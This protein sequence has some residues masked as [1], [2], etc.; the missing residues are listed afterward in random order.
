MTN[1]KKPSL[2]TSDEIL[3]NQ[4]LMLLICG[5]TLYFKKEKE[6]LIERIVKQ[7]PILKKNRKRGIYHTPVVRPEYDNVI[8]R[9][10]LRQY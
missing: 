4:C 3:Q 10:A 7:L 8:S 6:I 5:F 9:K 1:I 2:K